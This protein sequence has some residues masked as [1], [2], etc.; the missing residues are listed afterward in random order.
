MLV[1]SVSCSL[2]I[3]VQLLILSDFNDFDNSTIR[4]SFDPD[5]LV[6]ND[7]HAAPI[8]IFNDPVNEANV[9]VFVLQL[10][11]VNST[12][13]GL[14]SLHTRPA[15]LCQIIDDDSKCSIEVL[16][17]LAV[18]CFNVVIRIGFEEPHYTYIEPDADEDIDLIFVP[19][20]NLTVNGPIYLAKED[21]V[22]S[23]QTFRIIVQVA[24]LV[25][26]GEN[27]NPTTLGE[28]Y[29]LGNGTSPFVVAFPPNMQRVVLP[30]TLIHD[31]FPEG[32]EAF[33]ASSSV[34]DTAEIRGVTFD[35][36]GYLP[37]IAL[38]AETFVFIEDDDARKDLLFI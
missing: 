11:L 38:S 26:S 23:E 4:I 37:P 24:D 9:Q 5:E 36:P 14:V 21:N 33:R 1:I 20:T 28:D 19:R 6:N 18:I 31:D 17:A 8:R 27:I 10:R 3:V 7:E 32:T 22:Q 25:P 15:S 34:E 16:H 35:L 29:S 12:N 13:P 30:V 2:G